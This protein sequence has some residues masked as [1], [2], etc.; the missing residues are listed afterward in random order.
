MFDF[1]S[2]IFERS[3]WRCSRA[4]NA[5]KLPPFDLSAPNYL[6]NIFWE[7]KKVQNSSSSDIF[8]MGHFWDFWPPPKK[9]FWPQIFIL[10]HPPLCNK[11]S[12]T[13]KTHLEAP[14]PLTSLSFAIFL[15][16]WPKKSVFWPYLARIKP[17]RLAFIFIWLELNF[18]AYFG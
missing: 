9:I 18:W 7:W 2:Q 10:R 11:T 13:Q 14:T 17:N 4:Q 16:F 12:R 3:F 5:L 1:F 8:K 6:E 15:D